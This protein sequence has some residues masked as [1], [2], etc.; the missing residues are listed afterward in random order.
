MKKR[1]SKI[2]GILNITPDSFSGKTSC[3]DSDGALDHAK[4]M[5]NSGVDIIDVGAESTKPDTSS[6]S[7]EEE[8]SRLRVLPEIKRIA[9]RDGVAISLD[10]RNPETI[11]KYI[12][13]IDIINDV[14]GLQNEDIQN[15]ALKYQKKVV[16]MH[17]LSVPVKKGEF[18][19][20][21]DYVVYLLNWL[22]YKLQILYK[23]G[24]KKDQF[25]FDPGIGFG[26]SPKQVIDI[27]KGIK[28]FQSFGIEILIGH[29]RKSFLSQ[30]GEVDASKRDPET[31]ALTFYL[32]NLGVDY[33][34]VYD[35]EASKRIIKMAMEF[36]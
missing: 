6:I 25:I 19:D 2:F 35:V 32:A 26:N 27:L 16:L 24:F 12:E 30:F 21:D 1:E 28:K 31:H 9:D 8:I 7:L 23:K 4:R 29:A 34:R 14:S 15:I 33:V 3:F 13:Y 5:I 20:C 10:S 18:V 22:E 17:S 11:K 36:S